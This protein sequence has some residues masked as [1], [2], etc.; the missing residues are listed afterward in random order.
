[1]ASYF[2][3]AEDSVLLPKA[4]RGAEDL[5][6]LALLVEADV[7]NEFT[8]EPQP[9]D[10]EPAVELDSYRFVYLRDY[11]VDADDAG[12]ALKLALKRTIALV[13]AW[14]LRQDVMNPLLT[15]G[16][17]KAKSETRVANHQEPF[18]MHWDRFL[19]PFDSR[20]GA[21]AI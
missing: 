1:M 4:V 11:A 9:G 12:A 10:L 8:Q 18:P 2:V 20:P 19:R 16:G 14:R 3:S 7:I 6:Q 21:F 5:D 15:S 17:G 13:L